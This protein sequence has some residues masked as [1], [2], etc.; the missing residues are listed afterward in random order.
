MSKLFAPVAPC[1]NAAVMARA[2][3][4]VLPVS[5]RVGRDAADL[6]P[7]FPGVTI[8]VVVGHTQFSG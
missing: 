4:L 5:A 7:S 2:N 3:A 6:A 1:A 8:D